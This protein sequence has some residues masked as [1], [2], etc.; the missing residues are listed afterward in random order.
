MPVEFKS[1]DEV[2]NT[3][4]AKKERSVEK[5]WFFF[6]FFKFC[7]PVYGVVTILIDDYSRSR[8]FCASFKQ[9]AMFL[10][11][12]LLSLIFP[13][14][15]AAGSLFMPLMIV[16][17][18]VAYSYAKYRDNFWREVNKEFLGKV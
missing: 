12:A 11:F 9:P 16:P 17:I 10:L 7:I 13:A 15:L 4:A 14:I 3:I 2:R 6:H 5:S 18:F 1:R 8:L